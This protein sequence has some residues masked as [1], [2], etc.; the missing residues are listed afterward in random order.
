MLYKEIRENTVFLTTN[1]YTKVVH[2]LVYIYIYIYTEP[3]AFHQGLIKG[4]VSSYF[5]FFGII[6]SPM[7]LDT[8]DLKTVEE[9]EEKEGSGC[10]RT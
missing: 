9:T 8:T 5:F 4:F 7:L 1:A 2:Y 6:C 3:P 10:R